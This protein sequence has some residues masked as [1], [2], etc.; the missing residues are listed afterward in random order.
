MLSAIGQASAIVFFYVFPSG[1]FVPRWT[2]ALVP[3]WIAWQVPAIF[4]PDSRLNPST[5]PPV[6]SAGSWGLFLGSC[7]YAQL[8]RFFRV[9][10][11]AERQQTKWVVYGIILALGGILTATVLSWMFSYRGLDDL[12]YR[13]IVNTALYLAMVA[14][15]LSIGVAITRSRLWDI[16]VIVNRTLVYGLLS[17]TLA[18][19]YFGLIILLQLFV[20][21]WLGPG[22]D[23]TLVAISTLA[24]AALF[25]PV[26]QRAQGLIDRR[27]F[28]SKYDAAH[29]LAEFSARLRGEVDLERLSADLTAVVEQAMQPSRVALWLRPSQRSEPLE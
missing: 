19:I 1:R 16:G 8:Y 3:V 22:R 12:R 6:L 2:V 26:K 27:F 28:R 25:T 7:A 14:L 21:P 20:R 10:G 5:W 23:E 9:S 29:T 18:L 15:P 11:A 4:F 24:A 17:G 13:T